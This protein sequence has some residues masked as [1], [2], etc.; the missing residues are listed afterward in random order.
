[1][2]TE[3]ELPAVIRK[4]LVEHFEFQVGLLIIVH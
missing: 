4:E 1:M 2:S 3:Y